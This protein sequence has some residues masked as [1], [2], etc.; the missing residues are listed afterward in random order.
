[1][2]KQLMQDMIGGLPGIDEAM[3]FSEMMKY[4]IF[5]IYSIFSNYVATLA[6]AERTLNISPTIW[7]ENQSIAW[8]SMNTVW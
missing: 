6:I 2:T 7:K 4:D 5:V 3:S 8:A 1:M